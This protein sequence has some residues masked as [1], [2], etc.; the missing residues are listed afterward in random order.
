MSRDAKKD[1][2]TLFDGIQIVKAFQST[3]EEQ[4][5]AGSLEEQQ[6]RRQYLQELSVT[7][8]T[9]ETLLVHTERAARTT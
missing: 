6:A 9:L 4:R 3:M 2:V 5:D 8:A 7:R 1:A